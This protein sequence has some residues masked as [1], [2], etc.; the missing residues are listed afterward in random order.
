MT[1]LAFL[2]GATLF[3]LLLQSLEL[4][5]MHSKSVGMAVQVIC[6]LIGVLVCFT[7]ALFESLYYTNRDVKYW[8]L[9]NNSVV[10]VIWIAIAVC[11][12]FCLNRFQ[13]QS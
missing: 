12:Q 6:A 13:I 1:T 2:I 7:L 5:L 8:V 9:I 3:Q 10:P 11:C 4:V